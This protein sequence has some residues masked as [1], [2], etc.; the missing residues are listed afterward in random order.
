MP[1]EFK[2]NSIKE[3]IINNLEEGQIADVILEGC[4]SGWR[5]GH[6]KMC[7]VRSLQRKKMRQ[8]SSCLHF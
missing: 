2:E 8:Q 7:V 6:A 1:V 3:W 4:Q 5:G